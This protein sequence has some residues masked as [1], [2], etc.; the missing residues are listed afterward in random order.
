MSAKCLLILFAYLIFLGSKDC[1]QLSASESIEEFQ[2]IEIL[3]KIDHPE[4]P[5]L[6]EQMQWAQREKPY[7]GLKIYHCIPLD[8]ISAIKASVLHLGGAQVVVSRSQFANPKSEQSGIDL[9]KELSIEFRPSQEIFP[10]E[11]FD[12]YMD[13]GAELVNRPPPRLGY[14]ELTRSGEIVYEKSVLSA[15][16]LSVN[17]SQL[18]KIETFY[19]TADGF[20]RALQHFFDGQYR[21]KNYVL[22]GY[23]NVGSGIALKLKEIASEL[24]VVDVSLDAV[25]RARAGGFKARLLSDILEH[26]EVIAEADFIITATGEEGMLSRYFSSLDLFADTVLINMGGNDE[27]G[28]LFPKDSVQNQ[29][30]SFNFALD[31]PTRWIFLDPIFYAHNLAALLLVER[32][33]SNEVHPFPQEIDDRIYT[34]WKAQASHTATLKHSSER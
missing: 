19:G 11:V 4:I 18:K 14:V 6:L 16:V 21:G 2:L 23:G 32:S 10:G 29:K 27:Y 17:R 33:W 22:F 20:Y 8:L 34:R 7:L 12:I 1:A 26:S 15:P 28:H 24:I 3:K 5:F 9:L 13:C 31:H 25:E 30:E